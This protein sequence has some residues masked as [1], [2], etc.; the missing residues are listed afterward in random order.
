MRL[1]G[2]DDLISECKRCTV[3]ELGAAEGLVART[4]LEN[5][6]ALV[7]GFE[8]NPSRAST[9][10]ALLADWPSSRV[11]VSDLS[12]W[13]AFTLAN[14]DL[15]LERYDIVLY[16]GLHQ[17]LP[18]EQRMHVFSGALEKARKYIA[19][20]TPA[21]VMRSDQLSDHLR[22]RGFTPIE[23]ESSIASSSINLGPLLLGRRD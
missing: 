1:D 3:L 9:A 18:A 23:V 14:A 12:C 17:H 11:R 10:N 22:S 21:S 4:F 8:I 6:A 16:L 13:S 7:H 5:E 15:L 19:I 20:R 2:L